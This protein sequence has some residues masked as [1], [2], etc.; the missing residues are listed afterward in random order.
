MRRANFTLTTTNLGGEPTLT[1]DYQ[2]PAGNLTARLAD[3]GGLPAADEVD[4]GFRLQ[5]PAEADPE[6]VFSLTRRTTGEYLLEA[7]AP[8]SEIRSLVEAARDAGDKY[9]VNIE[10]PSGET[11]T[12]S[13][14]TLL[15]YDAEG[16]LLRGNSLIP[17][18]V[19]M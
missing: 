5:G 13:K 10:R 14:E 3:A 11:V 15:V 9:R 17:S 4:A 7:N 12:F 18:G 6:G 19:Q 1:L 16:N 2:G 8:A